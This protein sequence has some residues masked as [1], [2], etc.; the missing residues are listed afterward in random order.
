LF[1]SKS[2]ISIGVLGERCSG[3]AIAGHKGRPSSSLNIYIAQII[4]P[5]DKGISASIAANLDPKRW[6]VDSVLQDPLCIDHTREMVEAYF[7][8]IGHL[9]EHR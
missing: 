7:D 5:H 2:L 1:F 8:H 4:G 3:M 6:D 9:S